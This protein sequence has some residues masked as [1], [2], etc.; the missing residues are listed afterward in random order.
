MIL[1]PNYKNLDCI[2]CSLLKKKKEL[3]KIFSPV[4]WLRLPASNS[5]GMGSNPDQRT[6]IPHALWPKN[7][8]IQ[9]KQHCN[10]FNKDFKNYPLFFLNPKRKKSICYV[11]ICMENSMDRRAWQATVLGT[12]ELDTTW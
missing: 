7:P 3:K 4:L 10:K 6:K 11:F 8:N 5:E 12:A 9:Q 2:S 1:I